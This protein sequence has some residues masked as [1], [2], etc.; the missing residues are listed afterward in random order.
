MVLRSI[1]TTCVYSARVI[2]VR[3][4]VDIQPGLP[5]FTIIGLP[6][7]QIEEARDRVRAAIRNS[8]FKMPDGRITVNLAPSAIPKHGT[9]FDLAIAMGI[10]ATQERFTKPAKQVWVLG[11][12]SLDGSVEAFQQ[13]VV[14]LVEAKR[15]GII[16]IVPKAQKSIAQVVGFEHISLVSSLSQAWEMY[17]SSAFTEMDEI[18]KHPSSTPLSIS[19]YAIDQVKSQDAI[20]RAVLIALAGKHSLIMVGAAGSG[21]TMLAH[22]AHELLP[23]F[24]VDEQLLSLQLHSFADQPTD[25]HN[26]TRP[27]YSPNCHIT[28]YSL[29]GGG[30][31]IKPGI[32]SLASG[33]LLFLD[34]FAEMKRSVREMLRQPMQEKVIQFSRLGR[35][36]NFPASPMVWAAQNNC[37]CGLRG[38]RHKCVCRPG[39]LARYRK[40]LSQPILER[41]NLVVNMNKGKYTHPH[42]PKK[43]Y[44]GHEIASIVQRVW[45]LPEL[46]SKFQHQAHRLLFMQARKHDYSERVITSLKALASTIAA[47]DE[48]SEITTK[49]ILEALS[50]RYSPFS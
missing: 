1:E 29:F 48:S 14:V 27:F 2:P 28:E 24:T 9:S 42:Q 47:V 11:E 26:L 43:T 41:F 12:L 8:G 39:D 36:V 45:R 30:S 19:Q 15:R 46:P 40:S 33:G 17:K 50:Y 5:I 31:Q 23:L 13:L 49:H 3:V 38:T 20:K 35:T 21:K 18:Q 4:E 37:P 16:T 22:A 32:I 25:P 34:E 7:K 44:L 10:L 6:D